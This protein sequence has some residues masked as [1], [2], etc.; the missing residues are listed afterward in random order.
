MAVHVL[1]VENEDYVRSELREGLEYRGLQVTTARDGMEGLSKLETTKP[2]VIV[3]NMSLPDLNGWEVLQMIKA[4]QNVNDIPVVA[5]AATMN[6]ADEVRASNL[7]CGDFMTKPVLPAD[8]AS[9]VMR[10]LERR[11]TI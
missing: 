3:L 6:M 1:L 9:H 5:M 8:L 2:D 7:G 11:H 4:D 10:A